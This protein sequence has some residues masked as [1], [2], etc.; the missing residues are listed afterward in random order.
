[1]IDGLA[2]VKLAAA[3]LGPLGGARTG[4]AGTGLGPSP[5]PAADLLRDAVEELT[6]HPVRALTDAIET[7]RRQ[8]ALA[9]LNIGSVLSGVRSVLDMGTRPSSSLD[10][11]I[12]S[13]RRFAIADAPLQR[14]KDVKNALGGR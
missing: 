10:V 4:A 8:P 12:G 2:G 14:F 1:M 9:A 7:A 6:T 13:N 5:S 11:E 3:Y